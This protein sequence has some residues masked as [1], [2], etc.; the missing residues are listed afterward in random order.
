M[1]DM[2]SILVVEDEA[3]I[4]DEIVETLVDDGYAVYEASNGEEALKIATKVSVE[5]ILCDINMP[6][7]SGYDLMNTVRTHHPELDNTQFLF[8]SAFATR[9]QI[10]D[11]MVMGADDYLTKPIDF[12]LLLARVHAA[13]RR[14]RRMQQARERLISA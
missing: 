1:S 8:L 12:E 11:G 5:V 9:E 4:R 13:V 6:V 7:M 2:G 10:V 14:I 3:E